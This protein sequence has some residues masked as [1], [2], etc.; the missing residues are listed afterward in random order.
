MLLQTQRKLKSISLGWYGLPRRAGIDQGEAALAPQGLCWSCSG[1]PSCVETQNRAQGQVSSRKN[2]SLSD[3]LLHLPCAV[4]VCAA[5]FVVQMNK[6]VHNVVYTEIDVNWEFDGKQDRQ[7]QWAILPMSGEEDRRWH[8][9]C[10]QVLSQAWCP[11]A[12]VPQESTDSERFKRGNL[13]GAPE[14]TKR[15]FI[16]ELTSLWCLAK[17]LK[18]RSS[19]W[20][21]KG[22]QHRWWTQ[23][24]SIW[25]SHLLLSVMMAKK[26]PTSVKP[27]LNTHIT[28]TFLLLFGPVLMFRG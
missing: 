25:K 5:P 1:R 6:T 9:V 24:F 8:S 4:C 3:G 11:M 2:P 10:I 22:T 16:H 21:L 20:E 23:V 15:P 12:L 13:N 17:S 26:Q 27:V 7:R 18:P 19:Q 14:V 28:D